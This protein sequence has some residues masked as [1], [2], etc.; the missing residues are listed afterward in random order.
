MTRTLLLGLIFI[1][2]PALSQQTVPLYRVTVVERDVKAVNYQY[3]SGPTKVDFRGTVLMPYAGGEATVESKR[4]RTE[5]SAKLNHVLAPGRFGREYLTYVLWAISPEGSPHNLGEIVPG[6]SDH[7][8]I[9]V[10]TD[11]QA[12]GLIVT[13]EPYSA[14]RQPGDIVVLENEIRP[15]TVGKIQ[16]IIAKYDLMPRGH[17]TWNVQGEPEPNTPKVSMREYEAITQIYQ[18][19]NAI[20]IARSANAE[21]FAPNTLSEAE[22]MLAEARRLQS[23]KSDTSLISQTA[24][25]AIQTAEDARLIAERRAKERTLPAPG[26]PSPPPKKRRRKPRPK[27]SAPR[28]KPMP[29]KHRPMPNAP[30]AVTPKPPLPPP[31]PAPPPSSPTP[32][33]ARIAWCSLPPLPQPAQP[34]P[35]PEASCGCAC[36]KA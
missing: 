2:A 36:S 27:P 35:K 14:V 1:A 19:Q 24:R 33:Q 22:S 32:T 26:L 15:D 29:P 30:R 17:Y 8:S 23:G 11:L 7:A 10:T 18:A 31:K 3:R 21:K 16:P 5:I 13:A 12:F 20:G 9:T 4:G 28:P 25:A 34:T 6:S